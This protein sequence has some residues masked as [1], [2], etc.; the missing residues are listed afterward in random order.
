M[1]YRSL[2]KNG[3]RISTIGFGAWAM[4]GSGWA[5]SWGSQDDTES[6]RAVHA[7]LDA[8]ITFFD[9]AAVYG[10]GHS[11]EVLGRALGARRKDVVLATKCGLVWD[12]SKRI[13]RNGHY[14]SVL[15][16]AEQSLRRLGT[17]WIDLY[18]LHWPDTESGSRVEDT[19]RAME[20]LVRSGKVRWVGLSN[21]DA[22]GLG[23]ALQVRHIDALQPPYSL[24]A[25]QVEDRVLPVCQSNG[26]GVVA[27]SPLASGLL[28][29]RYGP[30]TRFAAED[31]RSRSAA[32]TGEGLRRN[33]A[34][35]DRLR[36]IAEST[37]RTVAQL[38][39]A[40]VLS[41]P[42]M[43]AAIVGVRHPG[44]VRDAVPAADWNL[45]ADERQAIEA[46][47]TT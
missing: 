24:L 44:H 31:W 16:E 45:S 37:G 47:R 41:H 9:T 14:A 46:A 18:Q 43:T 29:G 38:A 17:D 7:A 39:I 4:G 27:Y 21:F 34:M 19:L 23:R 5:Y 1:Q 11:E 40:W 13:H 12:E 10:L 42:A 3:P 32:H 20:E 22:E 25:R 26:V 6:E 28:S 2:G 15:R 35:V 33:L 30:D 36:P 8:G